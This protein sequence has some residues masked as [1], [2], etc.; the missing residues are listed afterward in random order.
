M[1][2]NTNALY[3]GVCVPARTSIAAATYAYP[4]PLAWGAYGAA[5]VVG[6][7]HQIATHDDKQT[8]AFGQP[9]WWNTGRYV[10]VIMMIILIILAITSPKHMWIA[11]AA[12]LAF[13]ASYRTA[14]VN[15]NLFQ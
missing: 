14:S 2:V 8:G 15:L 11:Q 10:H 9:V 5:A 7:I 3:W 1:P 12:D 6:N 13:G 4:N